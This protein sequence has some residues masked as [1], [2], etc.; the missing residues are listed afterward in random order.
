[1]SDKEISR[2][3]IIQKVCNKALTQKHAA[4]ILGICKRQIIRLCKNFRKYG[5]IGLISK[6]RG[7]K[8][9]NYI[10]EEIKEE[11]ISIIKEKYYDFGP[12]LAHEK[13]IELHKFQISIT[14]IRNLMIKNNIW[15]P[16]KIKK[17][18][19][20]QMRPRRSRE[21]ELV[22]IDGSPHVRCRRKKKK[23]VA[24]LAA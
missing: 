2:L 5:R 13:L 7:V 24:G 12:V 4:K 23:N 22:Q 3:E 21:G 15:T 1:M 10:S 11:L 6:K 17:M 14:T 19:I 16:H 9:N 8:S 20:H 18:N